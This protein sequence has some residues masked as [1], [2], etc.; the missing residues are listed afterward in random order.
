MNAVQQSRGSYSPAHALTKLL[1]G[2]Q[3]HYDSDKQVVGY[4]DPAAV[5]DCTSTLPS[6]FASVTRCNSRMQ[7]SPPP[8]ALPAGQL[9]FTPSLVRHYSLMKAFPQDYGAAL[10][11]PTM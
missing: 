9:G 1:P 10:Y 6:H 8:A 11:V 3:Q 5:T 7:R 2:A 4:A